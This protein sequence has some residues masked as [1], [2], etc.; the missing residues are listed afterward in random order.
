MDV[1][2]QEI[3]VQTRVQFVGV[4]LATIKDLKLIYRLYGKKDDTIVQC[5]AL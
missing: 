5:E 4:N 3:Q 2:G 1:D